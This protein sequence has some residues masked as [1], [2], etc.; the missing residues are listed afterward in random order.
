DAQYALG[1]MYYYGIDTVRDE[2]TATLW[3]QRASAQGQPL[4]KKALKLMN[5]GQDFDRTTSI[6]SSMIRQQPEEDVSSMNQAKPSAPVKN[7]LPNYNA[8]QSN[9]QQT[10]SPAGTPSTPSTPSSQPSTPGLQPSVQPA[11]PGLQPSVQPATPGLQPSVQPG[12]PG[13]QQNGQQPSPVGA[14]PPVDEQQPSP[15]G[16]PSP[17]DGQQL[18]PVGSVPPPP[19]NTAPSTP[20]TPPPSG[21][22][23]SYRINPVTDPRLA[24]NAMPNAAVSTAQKMSGNYTLQLMGTHDL[25]YLK[26]VRT[27]MHLNGKTHYAREEFRGKPWYILTYG[28]YPTVMQAHAAERRLPE[29][30]QKMHPWVKAY[31]TA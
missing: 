3:I 16:A 21:K 9:G 2:D 22:K 6:R 18:S 13:L 26:H 30:V 20:S 23:T 14:P 11:T 12:T 5:A 27:A 17:I 31:P 4:A 7:Y 25:A 29:S 1:Y 8:Q 10:P 24:S 19:T 15:I 28:R